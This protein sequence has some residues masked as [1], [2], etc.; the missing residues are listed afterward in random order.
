MGVCVDKLKVNYLRG[1]LYHVVVV[2][3]LIVV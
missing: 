2:V 1:S 3:M